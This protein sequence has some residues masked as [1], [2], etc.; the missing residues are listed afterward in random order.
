MAGIARAALTMLLGLLLAAT[1]WTA[2]PLS[3][4]LLDFQGAAEVLVDGKPQKMYPGQPLPRGFELRLPAR[5]RTELLLYGE[6]TI[7]RLEGPCRVTS[8]AQGLRW[9]SGRALP[10]TPKRRVSQV[11]APRGN[12]NIYGAATARRDVFPVVKPGLSDRPVLEWHAL[13]P[14]P[15]Q[16]SVLD[17]DKKL[18]WEAPPT[19][20]FCLDY[21]GPPLELDTDY[22]LMVSA[23]RAAGDRWFRVLSPEK[24][25]RLES[26]REEAEKLAQADAY[27]L[28]MMSYAGEARLEQAVQAGEEAL[29][30][31]PDSAPTHEFMAWLFEQLGAAPKAREHHRRATELRGR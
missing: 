2:E 15:F 23:G 6:G 25:A 29:R 27:V 5:A 28:L 19:E 21:A 13:M 31:Q 17:S 7:H 8:D 16:V 9:L 10:K 26:A 30:R 18:I 12:P 22:F 11:L 20:E 14:G 3:A 1:G 4:V 24:E